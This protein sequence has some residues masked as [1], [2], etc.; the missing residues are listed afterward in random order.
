MFIFCFPALYLSINI[1]FFLI[2][3][4]LYSIH[5]QKL[6]F[7]LYFEIPKPKTQTSVA[8]NINCELHFKC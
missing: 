3:L 8:S 7:F 4:N 1:V 5:T 2:F 6:I